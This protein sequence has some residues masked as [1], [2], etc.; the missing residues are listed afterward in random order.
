MKLKTLNNKN[1][2][3]KN[4]TK[5]QNNSDFIID[6][7]SSIK[8]Y[9]KFKPESI[10][11]I[12]YA[13]HKASQLNNI[14][15]NAV[16]SNVPI[17]LIKNPQQEPHLYAKIT[18]TPKDF[19]YLIKDI[20]TNPD[21]NFIIALD[22]VQDPANVGA[23]VRS[24]AFFNIKYILIPSQRQATITQTV[25]NTSMG[26]LALVELVIV[27]NIVRALTQLKEYGF[28]VLGADMQG[29]PCENLCGFYDKIV[30]VLG[31]ENK[32]LSPLVIK[33]SD[34]LI[35]ISTNISK[36]DSLNVSVAAGILMYSLK[37]KR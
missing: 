1:R 22:H 9:L 3:I 7:L 26:G 4:F 31:N 17:E 34:K 32:G 8:E 25:V 15:K 10:I 24:A 27:N 13:K 37:T 29:E 28:W 36:L 16:R 14:F 35:K 21:I 6:S 20:K 2:F 33:K 5:Q 23:I 11:K 30:L 18:V 19:N 12:R